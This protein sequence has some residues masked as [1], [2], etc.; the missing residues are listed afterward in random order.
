MKPGARKLGFTTIELIVSMG[1][2]SL[3]ILA[4]GYIFATATRAVNVS[5]GAIEIDSNIRAAA[6][7]IRE[8]MRGIS[9]D[10]FLCIV[11]EGP[12]VDHDSDPTTPDV[13]QYPPALVFCSTGRFASMTNADVSA[14]AAFIV[15]TIVRDDADQGDPV[16]L[17]RYARLLTGTGDPADGDLIGPALTDVVRALTPDTSGFSEADISTNLFNGFYA[18]W[19][20]P[21]VAAYGNLDSNPITIDEINNLWP[22]VIGGCKRME[23]EFS[24]GMAADGGLPPDNAL[25]WLTPTE[26][27]DAGGRNAIPGVVA[28]RDANTNAAFVCWTRHAQ[29]AWP[30]AI[31]LTLTLQDVAGQVS[32]QKIEI[33]LNVPQ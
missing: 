7:Q 23:I 12:L 17:A 19:I 4:V 1:I 31:R 10:A 30:K 2:L 9:K 20:H 3:I 32:E 21:L 15:Y 22:Y 29:D 27:V 25:V 5:E 14:N 13:P 24:D 28:G 16:I 26:V 6:V 11:Q 33:I 8:D 18:S